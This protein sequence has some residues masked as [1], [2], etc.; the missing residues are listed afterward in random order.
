MDLLFLSFSTSVALVIFPL[1]VSRYI[2][3]VCNLYQN[4]VVVRLHSQLCATTPL[5]FA[6]CRW[7]FAR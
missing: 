5:T 4:Q 1:S 7:A 2:E 3:K 6:N